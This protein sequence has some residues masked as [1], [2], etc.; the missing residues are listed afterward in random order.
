VRFVGPPT[1]VPAAAVQH[2]EGRKRL[3]YFRDPDGVVLELAEYT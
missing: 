3:C 2:A 1:A